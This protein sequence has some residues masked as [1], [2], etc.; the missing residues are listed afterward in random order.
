MLASGVLLGSLQAHRS[1][2]VLG[3][4]TLNI[5][6]V[7]IGSEGSRYPTQKTLLQQGLRPISEFFEAI[8]SS[9]FCAETIR[10]HESGP[11]YSTREA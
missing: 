11:P 8:A 2:S 5:L 3:K 7:S 10:E 6:A 4:S 9:L 1:T